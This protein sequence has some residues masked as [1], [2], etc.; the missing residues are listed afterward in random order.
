MSGGVKT[1]ELAIAPVPMS[2]EERA[3]GFLLLAAVALLSAATL[4]YEVLLTRLLAIVQWHHF[5]FLVISLALLG[6]GASGAFLL[7]AGDRIRLPAGSFLAL[8]ALAFAVAAP[9]C[10]AIA[11][12]VPFNVLELPWSLRP[13]GWLL[14]IELLL[15]VPFFIAATG[16]GRTLIVYGDR[17]S[18][19]YA[20]DLAGAGAGALA[21][22]V[23][24][25]WLPAGRTLDG[26]GAMAALAGATAALRAPRAARWAFLAPAAGLL[27]LLLSGA[28]GWNEL[29]ISPFKPLP[30][31][32]RASGATLAETRSGPLGLVSAVENEKVPFRW[33]PGLSLLARTPSRSRSPSSSM[34][35]GRS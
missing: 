9:A 30:Q 1:S 18:R 28:A 20:A 34:P 31:A 23:L 19:V 17:L 21:A 26:L 3:P 11:Q 6:F 4:G 24:L 32:L 25:W 15:A 13:F 35:A 29:R 8:T 7:V 5:A 16:I 12:H 33:A 10:F 14:V 27:L 22:V 2:G